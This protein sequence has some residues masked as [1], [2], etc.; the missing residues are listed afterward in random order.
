[1]NIELQSTRWSS[2]S[3]LDRFTVYN[4]AT[5]A[6]ICEVQGASPVEVDAAVGC[7]AQAQ[8]RWRERPVAERA[9]VLRSIAAALRPHA[10]ELARLETQENGKPFAQARF[11]DMEACIGSFEFFAA[12][13]EQ[14]ETPTRALGPI[15][16][17]E[18]LVP[19]GVV[20]GILPFNW[21]PIHFAAKTAPALAM[22]N[23]V[24]LKPGEQAPLT[25][26]R[27]VEIVS[28]VLPDDVLH[29]V[30]GIAAVGQALVTHPLM[31]KVSF[32]GAPGTGTKVLQ[33]IAG[34]HTP[35]LMELG[36]KNPL[37]VFDDADLDAALAGAI[38]GAYFNKGEACTA[39][40]RVLVQR[41][42][43]DQL[44]A[45]L[46]EATA[47]LRVGDGLD[48]TTHVG[49][50]VSKAQQ[51]RVLDYIELGL[52][53]GAVR[54]AQAALPDDPRLAHGYYVPPTVLARVTPG[55]RVAR[56]EIFGPVVCVIPF[57]TEADAIAIA[58]DTDFGLVAA[59]YTRDAARAERVAARIEAGLVFINNYNRNFMG[60]PF[61]GTKA[62][63][64]GR[65][66]CAQTLREFA[67]LRAVRRPNGN[68]PLPRWPVLDQVIPPR[69]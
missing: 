63:G 51:Q 36:G 39:A 32:T 37:L 47:R 11:A 7:A 60:S 45:R 69:D 40:S 15:D 19:Y 21:P 46:A 35:A 43:H 38:E 23:A 50:L 16:S 2:S 24:V 57:D 13:L 66:H 27:L 10:D 53:E 20:A 4:P 62:S 26:M 56:E 44:L 52:R 17:T 68:A 48:P 31:R 49:P 42:V 54:A 55:M 30:P 12:Q 6:A 58:N 28:G 22:G 64:Y 18:Q 41:G 67:Y 5:G 25:V 34:R 33:A 65:E 9:Q 14:L 8:Q 1:M 29:V 3:P 59:V 61:G